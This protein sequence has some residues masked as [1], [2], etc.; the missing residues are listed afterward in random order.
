VYL[1]GDFKQKE[2]YTMGKLERMKKDHET[3]SNA[4]KGSAMNEAVAKTEAIR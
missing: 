4:K 1:S 3:K 2:T